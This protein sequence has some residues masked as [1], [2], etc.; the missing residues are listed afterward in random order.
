MEK[1]DI[2]PPLGLIL[3]MSI[4]LIVSLLNNSTQLAYFSF[5]IILGSSIYIIY[6]FYQEY[7]KNK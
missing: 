7:K 1:M 2:L 4:F 6:L 5:G 3:L